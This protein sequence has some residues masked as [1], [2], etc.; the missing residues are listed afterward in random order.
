MKINEN[1]DV[2]DKLLISFEIYS[3][4]NIQSLKRRSIYLCL[5]KVTTKCVLGI[6]W[7]EIKK[8]IT[9]LLLF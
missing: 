4:R 6:K 5:L 9:F 7:L 8:I 3:S 1:N 2:D